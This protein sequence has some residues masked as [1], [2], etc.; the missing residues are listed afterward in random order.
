MLTPGYLRT[1]GTRIIDAAGRVVRLAGVN[2]YGF[3]CPS[4]VVGGL[5][6][7]P[8]GL[9]CRQ[10]AA[11]G[12]NHIRLPFSVKLVQSNPPITSYLDRNPGLRGKS[13][14]QIMDAVID[15]AGHAGLRVVLDSH[16]SDAG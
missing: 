5:D 15:S 11:M 14:L 12:F 16:R 7:Q 3:D 9:I 2:W 6:H 4:M 8:L 1:Q 13:A 10:I